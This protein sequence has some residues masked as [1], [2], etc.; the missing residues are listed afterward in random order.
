MGFHLD[1]TRLKKVQIDREPRRSFIE[2]LLKDSP[3]VSAYQEIYPWYGQTLTYLHP[4]PPTDDGGGYNI[5]FI[6]K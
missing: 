1:P 5:F 2:D 3:K 4:S 6:Y